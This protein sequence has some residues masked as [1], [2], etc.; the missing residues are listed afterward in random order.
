MKPP[1]LLPPLSE[2]EQ[3]ALN[4]GLRSPD[5]FILRRCQILLASAAGNKPAQIARVIGCAPQTVRNA[6]HHQ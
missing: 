1:L 4:L 3:L 6:I 5:A 2:S